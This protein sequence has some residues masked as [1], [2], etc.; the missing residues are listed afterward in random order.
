MNRKALVF[1]L[2]VLWISLSGC[3]KEG[4]GMPDWED[5][6][7]DNG[8]SFDPEPESSPPALCVS[9]RFLYVAWHDERSEGSNNIYLQVSQ[10]GG[11]S[12]NGSDI[13]I[14]SNPGAEWSAEHAAIAC[15]GQAVY[16]VWE[17]DRDGDLQNKAIYFNASNDA[18]NTWM[19]EDV[20]L[21]IDDEGDWNSLDPQIEVNGSNIYVT[22]Y[23]GR[24]G[25]YDI[26]YN[27]SSDSGMSWIGE[28]RVDQDSEGIAYSAKPR[29]VADGIGHVHL[30]WE[31]LRN[32]NND[33][34]F[35]TS[36]DHGFNWNNP[37]T[38]IDVDEEWINGEAVASEPAS[39]FGGAVAA[40]FE[41]MVVVA[42]HDLRNGA[43]SD[44]YSSVSLD[45][46]ANFSVPMRL[47][48][49]DGAGVSDSLFPV[50]DVV[51]GDILVAFRDDRQLSGFDVY[52]T[53]S[54]DAGETFTDEIPVD[55][56]GGS[57]HSVEPK[58]VAKPN[59]TIA[60]AW[61][62]KGDAAAG[63]WEDI[64]YNYSTD[65][66][67]SWQNDEIRVDDDERHSA[68]SIGMQMALEDGELY[69]VWTDYR[70]GVGD[71][72]FRR[73]EL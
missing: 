13:R 32:G 28:G 23:D 24:D 6:R 18:G 8:G 5:Q 45:H 50:L 42:W 53:K 69:F 71:I 70:D 44:I 46:G 20:N 9:D 14:N 10:D 38:R 54:S 48:A 22:W 19:N 15:A 66:G 4:G 12:W 35:N 21:T 16:V 60:I 43:Y 39:S 37:D 57:Y 63:N 59:G 58:M 49:G 67:E 17:D 3:P 31:D 36:A 25:A 2:A 55:T 73:M 34:Y 30:V 41:G 27:Y 68:R 61:I 56:D 1:G 40:E 52:F 62:D 51:D 7:I 26:Y 72:Y 33:I 64:L 47:D 65:G 11:D 29:M